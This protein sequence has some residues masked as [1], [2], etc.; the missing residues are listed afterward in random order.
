MKHKQLGPT[1]TV[2]VVALAIVG[3][4]ARSGAIAT[5]TAMIRNEVV[6]IASIT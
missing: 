2:T 6:F 3:Y 4:K 5:T 1:C